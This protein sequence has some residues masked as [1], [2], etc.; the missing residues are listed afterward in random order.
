MSV[1]PAMLI[2]SITGQRTAAAAKRW[3]CPITQLD[4][5]P[6]PE[7]PDTYMCVVSAKPRAITAST[8][9]IRSS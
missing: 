6:P 9:A 3:V 8:P 5:T 4:S 7:H 2:Q 1:C